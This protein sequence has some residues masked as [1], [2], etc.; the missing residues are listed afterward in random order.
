MTE[1]TTV[2][3]TK[4]EINDMLDRYGLSGSFNKCIIKQGEKMG[5]VQGAEAENFIFS[6]LDE[7]VKLMDNK[8]TD[9]TNDAELKTLIS[10]WIEEQDRIADQMD[11]VEE[12]EP[13][14]FDQSEIKKMSLAKNIDFA[15]LLI[16][17][18]LEKEFYGTLVKIGKALGYHQD[19][20]GK[21]YIFSRFTNCDEYLTDHSTK[22]PTPEP[23]FRGLIVEWI[24]KQNELFESLEE[25]ER[26][27][28][29]KADQMVQVEKEI[30]ILQ[31]ENAK[32]AKTDNKP[33]D[34]ERKGKVY[35][36]INFYSPYKEDQE[37]RA[38]ELR[39]K[40]G[41][42]TKVIKS[43]DAWALCWHADNKMD[44]FK[45]SIEILRPHLKQRIWPPLSGMRIPG[46]L[47]A[48]DK[49]ILEISNYES[50]EKERKEALLIEISDLR[51]GFRVDNS[52]GTSCSK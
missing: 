37:E 7:L 49:L 4:Y 52:S 23:E 1:K 15:N 22:I 43:D 10:G 42:S 35:H 26:K 30:K 25:Y 28:D 48:A 18:K 46:I 33:K 51:K 6:K 34:L 36:L 21:E 31:E 41:V 24:A 19:E 45:A 38:K 9:K 39:E 5:M 11:Q 40:W 17:F 8:R 50:S 2:S 12:N 27:E 32:K 44:E 29:V 13:Q 47:K 14:A 16:T 20:E 3:E